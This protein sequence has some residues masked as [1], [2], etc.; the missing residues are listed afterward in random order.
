MSFL[1]H[2]ENINNSNSQ[3]QGALY[4]TEGNQVRNCRAVKV[5]NPPGGRQTFN[6][7]GG[8]EPEQQAAPVSRRAQV[9]QQQPQAPVQKAPV[10]QQ[11]AAPQ[12]RQQEPVAA[13]YCT[14]GNQVRSCRAV[15]VANPPGG[16]QTFNIFGGN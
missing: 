13:L 8:Y 15:R 10:Q 11:A 2:D 6:I 3:G 5:A 7:F 14:E 4:C 16:K 9:P 12:Q 1:R